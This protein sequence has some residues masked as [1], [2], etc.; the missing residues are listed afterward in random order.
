MKRIGVLTSGGDSPGMNPAIRAV[1]RSGIY[2][3]L[4]VFGIKRGYEGLIE[5][6]IYKM[7]VGSVGGIINHGGTMLKTA[8]SLYYMTDEGFNKALESIKLNKLDGVI[9]IGG[10]GS[11]KGALELSK[12][13]I[14]VVGLPATID[15]DL[16]YSDYS[17]GFDTACNTILDAIS[18]IRDTS[19][20]H[21][22]VSVIEVMGKQSGQLALYAGITGGADCVLVPEV[23]VDVAK[24]CDKLAAGI[25]RDKMYSIILKAEGVK[26]S[27]QTLAEK[28]QNRLDIESRIVVLGHIQRGGAPTARDRMV[29]S[30]MG[31]EAV[32]HLKNN[33]TS[34]SLGI[35]GDEVVALDMDEALSMEK[36][37]DFTQDDFANIL[38]I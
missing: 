10:D 6:D 7:N 4:E 13:G 35:I 26:M 23:D 24:V 1:V 8:R 31:Y 11:L 30:K 9:V 22:R 25:R 15:N 32:Q 2:N 19:S 3:E 37:Y 34:K 17:I 14:P 5:N 18:K 29:A 27:T 20:S 16:G 33:G 28:I 21:D 38:S 12:A 36:A